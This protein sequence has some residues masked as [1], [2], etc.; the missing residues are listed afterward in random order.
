[1]IKRGRYDFHK[2]ADRTVRRILRDILVHARNRAM[3]AGDEP[4]RKVLSG[5]I[6]KT[7]P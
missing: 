2:V 7:R 3:T 4:A 5:L 6:A 1:M